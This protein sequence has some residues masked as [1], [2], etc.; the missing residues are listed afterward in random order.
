MKFPRTRRLDQSDTRVFEHAAEP[1]EWAVP[2]GFAFADCDAEALAPKARLAFAQGW[3]GTESFGF[4]SLVEVAEIAPDEFERVI[5]R[6]A[7]HFVERHGAP[8]VAAARPV[9]AEEARSAADLCD[10]KIHTLLALERLP[11]PDG[12]IER[13]RV[14]QP[15]RVDEHARIWTIERDDGR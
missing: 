14:I 4:A 6:L 7:R 1:G 5:D 12:V 13:F 15:E 3:L 11:G 9:A 8:D 2:G 10:H